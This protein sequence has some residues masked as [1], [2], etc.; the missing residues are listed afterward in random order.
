MAKGEPSSVPRPRWASI[1][2]RSASVMDAS[3]VESPI[4]VEREGSRWTFVLDRPAK[5][6]ALSAELVEAL[7][8]ALAEAHAGGASVIAFRGNGRNLS[9]G[10]DFTDY[11]A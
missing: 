3:R 1:R 2:T 9:A 7:I 10:F 4:A 6:N 11:E 5:A 8:A